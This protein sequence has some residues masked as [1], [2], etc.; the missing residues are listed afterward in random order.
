MRWTF[1]KQVDE[2]VA[3]MRSAGRIN[4][5]GTERAYR[6]ILGWHAEDCRQ[7]DPRRTTTADVLATL[8]RWESRNT[9]RNRLA[10]LSSFY[11]WM[12]RRGRRRDNPCDRIDRPRRTDPDPPR[13]SRSEALAL[14]DACE[15]A[16][17]R[18]VIFLGVLAGIRNQ[19]LRRLRGKHFGRQGITRITPDVGKGGHP[20]QVPWLPELVPVVEEIRA[21][22]GRDE[23]VVPAQRR[24]PQGG[25]WYDLPDTPCSGQAVW[26]LVKR[27]GDRAGVEGNPHALRR[28]F[29]D[30]VLAATGDVKL[31]QEL[32]GHKS[33][34]TTELYLSRK[35]LDALQS[36]VIGVTLDPTMARSSRRSQQTIRPSES[37]N[38][39]VSP[40]TSTATGSVSISPFGRPSVQNRGASIEVPPRGF[41]PRDYLPSHPAWLEA[42]LSPLAPLILHYRE[43]LDV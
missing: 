31:V 24:D 35:T 8:G 36:A 17:E 37:V 14:L 43:A 21:N 32:L 28:A 30:L 9:K 2:F 26:R 18:R 41:E 3:E 10:V 27:V 13:L 11:R 12:V 6:D 7:G 19:E 16:R 42:W 39:T 5:S 33:L 15:T 34:G 29:A 1:G 38:R 40:S 23:Y 22:V 25:V 4:S 20:R